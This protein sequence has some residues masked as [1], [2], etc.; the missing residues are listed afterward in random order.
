MPETCYL[1]PESPR[2]S[3]ADGL[4]LFLRPRE[5]QVVVA[6]GAVGVL[7]AVFFPVDGE[8]GAEDFRFYEWADVEAD[9]VVE[10][11]VPAYGLL[12]FRFPADV[13]VVG[14]ISLEDGFELP[15]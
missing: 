13:D 5:V 14:G 9:A 4:H 7:A 6:F 8:F 1:I 10:V 2:S 12:V 3:R 15:L 11:G